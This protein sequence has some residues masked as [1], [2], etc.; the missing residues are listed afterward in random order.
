MAL[1]KNIRLVR[2]L[3]GLTQKDIENRTNGAVK[4]ATISAVEKRD[5]TNTKG[6]SEIARVLGVTPAILLKPNLSA[7][8]VLG[9]ENIEAWE[10]GEP[11]E[12]FVDIPEYELSVAAGAGSI[13]DPSDYF[14]PTGNPSVR[15]RL[16]F[17]ISK[18]IKP[19]NCKRFKVTGD[20][21]E[22]LLFSGDK[23]LVDTSPIERVRTGAVYAVNYDGELRVKRLEKRID[24]TLILRSENSAYQPEAV[25]PDVVNDGRFFIIGRVIEKSSTFGF[26]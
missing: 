25:P 9:A 15:Y 11:D 24:G 23:I 22:P 19:E 10:G 5:S 4:Q 1:G 21:M 6:L 17:F 26:D 8:D 7:A 18:G 12:G 13:N 14:V 3:R 20:S 16:D 2:E